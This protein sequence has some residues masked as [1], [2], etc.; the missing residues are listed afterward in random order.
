MA[1]MVWVA[2]GAAGGIY[3]YKKVSKVVED[4][5]GRTLVGNVNAATA[6][7]N[8]FV[9]RTKH[10]VAAV[11][12]PTSPPEADGGAA[13]PVPLASRLRT[14]IPPKSDV[15]SSTSSPSADTPRS[16]APR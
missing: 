6:S 14:W 3:A 16:P 10:F 11:G 15:A 12:A 2:I 8:S 4:A 5:R 13:E 7:A 9:E 1:R